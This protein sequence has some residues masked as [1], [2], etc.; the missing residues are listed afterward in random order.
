ML[1]EIVGIARAVGPTPIKETQDIIR[2]IG[3]L[4]VNNRGVVRKI[5]NMEIRPLPKI[6]KKNRQ[7][8]IVGSHFYIRFDASPGV[9]S[10]VFRTLRVDPRMIRSTIVKVGGDSLKDLAK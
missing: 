10:E 8:F 7:S 9:Q 4:I 1:Y 5:E 6:M 3:K 2:T